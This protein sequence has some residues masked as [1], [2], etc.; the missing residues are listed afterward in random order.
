VL[1]YFCDVYCNSCDGGSKSLGGIGCS[2]PLDYGE[3]ELCNIM[4][5][6]MPVDRKNV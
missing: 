3:G 4:L 2:I 6:A 1:E 5:K